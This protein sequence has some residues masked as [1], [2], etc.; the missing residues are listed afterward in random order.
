M[1]DVPDVG[2]DMFRVVPAASHPGYCRVLSDTAAEV[3]A[4]VL[5]PTVSEELVH[6]AEERC[7][8]DVPVV[9]GSAE[10]VTAAGDKYLTMQSLESHGVPIPWFDLPT[11]YAS[12][13]AVIQAAGGSVV[14]KPRVSRGARG[15]VVID[16]ETAGSEAVARFWDGLDD[17]VLVQRFA[18]GREFAPVTFRSSLSDTGLCIVLEKTALREGRVGNAVGVRRPP[19]DDPQVE[20][21]ADV[22]REAGLA[23]ELTGPADVD[24][25]L[26]EDGMPVVLEVNARFGANSAAAPELLQ[27]VLEHAA[28][29]AVVG[30]VQV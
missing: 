27:A 23:L 4:G 15:V 19:L 1:R 11:R 16:P 9:I 18:P 28:R 6:V 13:V 30:G 17:T 7:V 25:R 2:V 24:V 29:V 14:V 5:I 22:A 8:F 20:A 10:S 12:A 3:G 21:V 26:R